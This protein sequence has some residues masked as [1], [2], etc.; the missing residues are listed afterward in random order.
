MP[1]LLPSI[2]NIFL[3]VENGFFKQEPIPNITR[4]I[5]SDTTTK[6]RIGA[7]LG[8]ISFI[9][10]SSTKKPIDGATLG[11]NEGPTIR[12]IT[13]HCTEDTQGS[14]GSLTYTV[15]NVG[16][17]VGIAAYSVA[18]SLASGS[19]DVFTTGGIA[20]ACIF[21]AV[22]AVLSYITS[23]LAKDTFLA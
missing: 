23:R 18:A 21:G 14:A 8:V 17:V 13:I 19:P 5:E 4:N 20:A 2:V 12:R 22:C 7:I 1:K 11:I 10:V 3:N 15:M 9:V 16:S 6:K